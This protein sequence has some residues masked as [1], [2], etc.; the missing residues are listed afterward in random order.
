MQ[1]VEEYLAT[2]LAPGRIIGPIDPK[3]M[4]QA[5]VSRFRVIPKANQLGKW[6][7]ILD[8]SSPKNHSMNDIPKELC[9]TI[10]TQGG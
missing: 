5:Q 6:R 1:P 9:S 8:L 4:P 10:D 7:L 3:T 2:E